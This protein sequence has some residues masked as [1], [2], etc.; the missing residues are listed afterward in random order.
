MGNTLCPWMKYLI[1][2]LMID[3]LNNRL[4]D[5][6]ADDLAGFQNDDLASFKQPIRL[7]V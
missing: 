6:L 4:A 5:R 7:T 1:H 3:R 2:G